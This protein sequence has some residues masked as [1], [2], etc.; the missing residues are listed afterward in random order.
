MFASCRQVL[1]D[2]SPDFL[3]GCV[4]LHDAQH[5]K[6]TMTAPSV[7]EKCAAEPSP[8]I[9][10]SGSLVGLAFQDEACE[11]CPQAAIQG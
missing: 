5:G 9:P 2:E 1:D 11:P 6:R 7:N 10:R 3:K 4:S 8:A